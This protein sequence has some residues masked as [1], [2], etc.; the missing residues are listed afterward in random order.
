MAGFGPIHLELRPKI[1][2]PCQRPAE[3]ALGVGKL[4]NVPLLFD[5]IPLADQ[6]GI[7]HRIFFDGIEFCLRLD[8]RFVAAVLN[9][10]LMCRDDPADL[11]TRRF[12]KLSQQKEHFFIELPPRFDRIETGVK[13]IVDIQRPES[14]RDHHP[15]VKH[16]QHRQG[17][18]AF[19][20]AQAVK[21]PDVVLRV[22]PA[23]VGEGI[24]LFEILFE[25][26]GHSRENTAAKDWGQFNPWNG[27]LPPEMVAGMEILNHIA[28]E[29][30]RNPEA[31]HQVPADP[32]RLHCDLTQ[33]G[34]FCPER[35]APPVPIL[36]A[37]GADNMHQCRVTGSWDFDRAV[38]ENPG[39]LI[40]SFRRLFRKTNTDVWED[41]IF[42][43][44]ERRFLCGEKSRIIGYGETAEDAEKIVNDFTAAYGATPPK[45]GGRFQ[46]IRKDR[47]DFKCEDVALGEDTV[48][49]GEDFALRYPGDAPAWH[50]E[51]VEKLIARKSGL[52]ILEGTPGTGK[53]TYL[54][55]LMGTLQETHRFYFIP[56]S[57]LRILSESDFIGFWAGERQIHS[58]K[59]LVVILEDADAAIMT[60]G[61]DNQEQVSA[62]L[63]LSDGMLGDFLSLQ[64][65]CTINCSASEID[66]ALVRPGRLL[67]HRVFERLDPSQAARLAA[68]IGKPLPHAKDYSLAEVF[69]G[70]GARGKARPHIGFGGPN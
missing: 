21:S 18:V 40:R 12:G 19:P 15:M 29:P 10:M 68:S 6:V 45:T 66:Q 31:R 11:I 42:Q 55:H 65:I 64:I 1:S 69:A 34:A 23:V 41:V 59:R 30:T 24:E 37:F 14:D 22:F 39:G 2:L 32:T 43:F 57:N 47:F 13:N 56:P 38:S 52:S 70:H 48:L 25:G 50:Q 53:T 33:G 49:T 4:R 9:K 36:A 7:S 54:R 5:R 51:F 20:A 8:E 27:D 44:G 26:R 61:K 58:D 60:R 62:L 63:N 3:D 16:V 67:S 35:N 46:L 28:A 17:L